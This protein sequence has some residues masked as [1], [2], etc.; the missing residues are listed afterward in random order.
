MRLNK[1]VKILIWKEYLASRPY[2][3]F[4]LAIYLISFIYEG[5]THYLEDSLSELFYKRDGFAIAYFL[6]MYLLCFGLHTKDYDDR[7]QHFMNGLPVPRFL[8]YTIKSLLP[9]VIITLYFFAET[10]LLLLISLSIDDIQMF[11]KWLYPLVVTSITQI[12]IFGSLLGTLSFLRRWSLLV[13]VF[14]F[15]TFVWL[16]QM[17]IQN[18]SYNIF[19]IA[20]PPESRDQAWL[21]PWGQLGGFLLGSTILWVIG[22]ILFQIR[23]LSFGRFQTLIAK[24]FSNKVATVFFVMLLVSGICGLLEVS[25]TKDLI[26]DLSK[27]THLPKRLPDQKIIQKKTK[28]FDFTFVQKHRKILFSN[29]KKWDQAYQKVTSYLKMPVSFSSTRI[30]V[31]ACNPLMQHAAGRAFWK[32]MQIDP[33]KN[34]D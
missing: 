11:G 32:K 16:K 15:F 34:R 21:I 2:I 13:L 19:A 31:D 3:L 27:K 20:N 4:L 22:L 7:T 9:M 8:I 33:R 26:E 6:L 28:H 30:Q 24:K 29:P 1:I 12:I 25:I 10:F 17:G 18:D 5:V 14:L 23:Y